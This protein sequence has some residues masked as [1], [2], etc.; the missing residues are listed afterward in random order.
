[1]ADGDQ[2]AQPL[3]GNL[4]PLTFEQF[5]G[6][7]T[8]TTRQGVPDAQMYWCD[9]FMPLAP[10]NLRTHWGIGS[11]LYTSGGTITCFDFYN[12]GAVPY[13]AVFQA[14]G[15][16]IQVN[17]ASSATATIVPSGTILAPSVISMG[18]SQ[19]GSQYLLIVANQSNGYWVWD[20]SLLYTAGTLAP[21]VVITDS[22]E[23]YV[24]PPSIYATGGSGFGA[25]FVATISDG[26]LSNIAITNPGQ[27]YIVGDTPS[28]V[29][30]GGTQAGSGA[31]ITAA[32]SHANGGSGGSITC[33]LGIIG[34]GQE[35]VTSVILNSSGSG[36]SA[37]AVVN[38]SGGNFVTSA[39]LS[40]GITSGSITSVTILN[41]GYYLSGSSTPIATISDP[42][43]Y[44]VSS[45]TIV[46]GG[47]GYGP[48]R[49]ITASGGGSPVSQATFSSNTNAGGTITSVTILNSGFYGS[50]SPPTLA[51]SDSAS[52][53]SATIS[54]MPYGVQGTAVESYQGH[55]WV[56]NGTLKQWSAP[57]SV[58]DFSTSAGG[59]SETS[60]SS[61][62]RVRYIGAVSTN[63]FLFEISDSSMD[64]ISGVQ[65]TGTVTPTTTFTEN[66]SDPEVGTPYP[67]AITTFG[68]EIFMA[69]PTG[70]YVSSGGSFVKISE[71][72]DGVYNTVPTTNFNANPFN[73]FQLSAAKATIFGK[74]VWM[75][76]VP[77][78]DPV[79]NATV[80]KLIMVRDKK[81]WWT[82]LQDVALTFIQGQEINSVYTAYGTDG[83][84][85]YPLFQQPSTAF[86][87]TV[88]T[89]LWDPPSGYSGAQA[90]SLF[91]SMWQ[92]NS[93]LSTSITLNI[94]A[95][96]VS[97]SGQYTNSATYT[98]TGPSTTG[99]YIT[100]PQAV[101]QQGISAGMTI[102]TNAADMTLITATVATEDVGFRG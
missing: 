22:G 59:G 83:T 100:P 51:I 101:G 32:L 91:W 25:K 90:E 43:Y 93:T 76:L 95:V 17:T 8:A 94:D 4:L 24:S 58:T 26:A 12:I 42:G 44:Y 2:K 62:Q 56:F 39:V 18:T 80:N 99:N 54:L 81:I 68:Q 86:T 71:S 75:V 87:K 33:V 97:A 53:A 50:N 6:V 70:V 69:N 65:T 23:G 48:S 96:G 7:N 67:A 9:G 74:R 92:C 21:T 34:K 30:S 41:Q 45:T 78:V 49:A 5:A 31:S 84:H 40:L 46:S 66:N 52:N 35:G 89:K 73:G 11:S 16:V 29:I 28:L 88:Q 10:R 19:W 13:A 72:M 47:S 64:Y 27:G 60:G 77:I 85:L 37:E 79:T 57:G 1:M 15:S 61:T 3:Q 63:G 82:S 98:L 102:E 38:V 14:D 20:G 36:Y 55:V